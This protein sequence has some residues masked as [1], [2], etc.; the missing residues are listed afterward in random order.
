GVAPV[1]GERR[2]PRPRDHR[3]GEES[4]PDDVT[5]G[6]EAPD[7]IS[8]TLEPPVGAYRVEREDAFPGHIAPR[9]SVARPA[10]AV[11]RSESLTARASVAAP[12]PPAS[13]GPQAASNPG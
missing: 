3:E 1:H 12:H 7:S 11:I 2:D 4:L 9:R 13:R 6:L 10:G 8:D 5:E